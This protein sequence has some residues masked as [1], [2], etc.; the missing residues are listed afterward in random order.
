MKILYIGMKYDYGE[1]AR[2]LSFEHYNFYDSLVK[3][4]HGQHEVIYFP[5][6]E[7]I[8]AKGRA[9]ANAA[10]I[11]TVKDLSPDLC[12]FFLFQDEILPETIQKITNSGVITYNWFADDH[13]RFD[14][15]SRHYAPCFS[16]SSTT[17]SLAIAKYQKIGCRNVLK[18]QWGCNHFLYKPAEG[19]NFKHN[20][21]FVGQPHG[22][23]KK[24]ISY[25]KSQDV[26]TDCFGL[27]WPH[28]RIAQEEMIAI[29][30]Q[31]R[32]NLNLTKASGGLA[33]KDLGKIFLTKKNG[34]LKLEPPRTWPGHF[35]SLLARKREQIKGRNF[36]IPGCGGFLISGYADNLSD[37][38]EP[39]KEIVCYQTPQDLAEKIKY[40]LSHETERSKIAQAGYRRTMNEHTYEKRFQRIFQEM[41]LKD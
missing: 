16:F 38:Y 8:T 41:G 14:D 4:D 17:D 5:V 24:V 33:L 27:G 2:G 26:T 20:V 10:L 25:L 6:D 9:G 3:M 31:S 21:S 35:Q 15:F 36:E 11:D 12:F 30:G 28:G 13:F 19:T 7:E 22:N 34:Q 29:F 40:Y 37:Y 23:R 32:I 1:K 39:G 18:T